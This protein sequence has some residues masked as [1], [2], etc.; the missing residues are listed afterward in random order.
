[1]E[2][3]FFL[4]FIII[5]LSKINFK[6]K[7]IPY[8]SVIV[9]IYNSEK[10]LP[11]CLQSIIAQSLKNIEIICIDDGSKDESIKIIKN[12]IKID[13]R[14][15]LISQKNRGSG[16][17]RNIGIKISK[18]KYLAFVDSDDLYP[19]NYTLELVYNKCVQ[20]N[21]L[22]CGGTLEI[23]KK[24]D[25]HF[26]ISKLKENDNYQ[27]KMEGIFNYSD[28]EFDF[29]FYRFIYESKFIKK[30]N[31][32]FPN[33][34]RYQDP[35][36]LINTMIKAKQYYILNISTYL[37]RKSHKKIKW[38]TR[39]I[40]DQYNGFEDSLLL[41]EKY[42]L[43]KLYC[44]IINRLNSKLFVLPTKKFINN[45]NIKYHIYK[46]LNKIN[47]KKL[48]KE[49]CYVKL[50]ITYKRILKNKKYLELF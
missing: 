20:N 23:L 33:Y 18:G 30:N 34:L 16:L 10:Y 45:I 14:I 1:M 32:F 13:N 40:L 27:I 8:I 3:K 5:F 50:N 11:F 49:N 39:K 48:K 24:I 44:Q 2:F 19:N 36:F 22:I 31:I 21:A 15:I 12:F 41:S 6:L 25:N 47:F 26:E 29:G 28:N 17:A 4:I 37:Y 46:V 43:K 9:P 7:I 35:P 42:N 38:N